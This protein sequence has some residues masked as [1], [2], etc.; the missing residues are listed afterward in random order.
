MRQRVKLKKVS[1]T[2][3]LGSTRLAAREFPHILLVK[4]VQTIFTALSNFSILSH[5]SSRKKTDF[6][7]FQFILN[8]I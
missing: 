5:T 3:V 8:S 7:L 1:F 4:L 6:E 2:G